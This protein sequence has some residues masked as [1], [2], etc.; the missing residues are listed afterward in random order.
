MISVWDFGG[1]FWTSVP[2]FGV[3]HPGFYIFGGFNPHIWDFFWVF[4]GAQ[5]LIW[6]SF[7][8]PSVRSDIWGFFGGSIPD[9]EVSHLGFLGFFVF[10]VQGLT[11]GIFLGFD[12]WNFWGSIPNFVISI[13]DFWIFLGSQ[14]GVQNFKR[15]E[16]CFKCGV[17]KAGE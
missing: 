13:W 2:G 15:R 5:S 11:F 17:P 12:I 9:F 4:F 3:S 1:F 7:G 10:P 14:C 8:V 6:D 16:K